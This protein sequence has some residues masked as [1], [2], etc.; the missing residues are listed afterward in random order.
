M[1]RGER[2]VARQ[3]GFTMAELL[4]AIGLFSVVVAIAA[5]G[6]VNA[7]RAQSQAA[8]LI[9]ANSNVSLALEQMAREIRTGFEFC[10][11][12]QVCAPASNPVVK[13]ELVFKNARSETVTYRLANNAIERGV[14]GANFAK[15]TGDNAV[16]RSLS[17]LPFGNLGAGVGDAYQPRVTIS[18]GVSAN[19]RGLASSVTNLQTTVSARLPLDL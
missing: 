6:F 11:G 17:F 7:L 5:G 19:E 18:V 9:A 14:G 13:D 2:S 16:I 10:A 8:A 4:V 15:I 3:Q 12:A 1:E